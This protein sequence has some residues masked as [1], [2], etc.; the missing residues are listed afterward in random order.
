MTKDRTAG[1][2]VAGEVVTRDSAGDTDSC[3]PCHPP[4]PPHPPPAARVVRRPGP[5]RLTRGF[6]PVL[7]APVARC[8]ERDEQFFDM[9]ENGHPVAD[10]C[11]SAGY[12]RQV[13]YRWRQKD[14]DF[15][16]RWRAALTVAAD[17]LEEEA[18]RR[19]RDGYVEEVFSMG[20]LISSRR[21]YSDGLL[22]A[23][24]KAVKPEAY[25][26]RKAASANGQTQITIV[27]GDGEA[28]ELL[29][30]LVAQN[31]LQAGDLPPALQARLQK[32]LVLSDQR[33]DP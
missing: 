4:H 11:L 24:L 33:S 22:L 5:R 1:S 27:I 20:E 9:L 2:A 25:R 31:K 21:K 7:R 18:D 12:T 30:K 15:G 29:L 6:A 13:V 8:D 3:H 32:N 16:Q 10:A 26:E 14:A 19:G 17:L 28:E 23:R